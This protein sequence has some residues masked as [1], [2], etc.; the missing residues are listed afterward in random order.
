[1]FEPDDE[2]DYDERDDRDE[3]AYV[4]KFDPEAPLNAPIDPA[5]DY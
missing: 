5:Q 3:E 1:M 4:P 2:Q